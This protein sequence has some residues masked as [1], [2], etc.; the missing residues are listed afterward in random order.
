MSDSISPPPA[1]TARRR[2]RPAS[3]ASGA[4]A[5]LERFDLPASLDG[6]GGSNRAPLA[7]C[8]ITATTDAHAIEAWLR[9]RPPDSHTWRA[10]RK[11]A[12]RLLLWAVLARGKAL[13]SLR[14][15]DCAAYREFL[16]QPP[17]RWTG[18][19]NTA[20]SSAQWRPFEGPL[21]PRSAANAAAILRAL[22]EWLTRRRYLAA[23]P[24][25]GV[26]AQNDLPAPLRQRSLD[27]AQWQRLQ[28]WLADPAM[29]P[30]SPATERLRCAVTLAYCTGMRRA[31][32]AAAQVGALRHGSPAGSAT[33]DW[34]IMV[35][36]G[37]GR[38][39]EVALP[40]P[41]VRSLQRYFSLRGLDAGL[42]GNP[43]ETPLLSA[44][45]REAPL[46]AG[47][48]YELVATAF[49]AFA[50]AADDPAAARIGHATP[51]WLRHSHAFRAIERGVSQQA[52]RR[53][54]GH[55][56]PATAALYCSA[57]RHE[58][59]R[60]IA[61]AFADALDGGAAAARAHR[62][63]SRTGGL[64]EV[65]VDTQVDAQAD[66]QADPHADDPQR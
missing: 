49:G 30:P 39:R 17:E 2:V 40:Q 29:Q 52:L 5:P 43:P 14:T 63:R 57:E 18:P 51:Q 61:R 42:L 28:D 11:E 22:F 56:S 59:Q 54:L 66:P 58:C 60:S 33:P 6:R 50:A 44:L 27:A 25:H 47:R 36:D 38:E 53:N 15:A 20:R 64:A 8:E 37:C 23:N 19:R 9:L 13:S 24:W 48:L 41:V 34:S 7:E 62:H 46:T 1:K 55:R 32:L 45:A 26:R 10:Y 65:L 35:N 12:E 21:S 4:I 3:A 31:E 16:A